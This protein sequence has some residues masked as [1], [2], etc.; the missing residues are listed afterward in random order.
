MQL[1][2]LLFYI[3]NIILYKNRQLFLYNNNKINMICFHLLS[4][5]YNFAIIYIF[6]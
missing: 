1:G 4:I 3:Q 5:Y 6:N 2:Y